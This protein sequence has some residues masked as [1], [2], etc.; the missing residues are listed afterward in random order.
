M[1]PV[2]GRF[3]PQ[4]V[5][6]GAA[7]EPLAN[8]ARPVASSSNHACPRAIAL[9]SAGSHLE[10]WLC[11]ANPGSTSLV[12]APRRL[13]STAAVSSIV[14]PLGSSDAHT[15]LLRPTAHRAAS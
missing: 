7:F 13:K 8:R 6:H 1:S 10:A 9:I 2:S 5:G 3:Q 4:Q 14:L 15:R 12:S 11:C